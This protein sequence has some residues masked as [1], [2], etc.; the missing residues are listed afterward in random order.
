MMSVTAAPIN[1]LRLLRYASIFNFSY[2]NDG[3]THRQAQT[4]VTSMNNT[5]PI[6]ARTTSCIV[7]L[8]DIRFPVC[9]SIPLVSERQ[10]A[11][12]LQSPQGLSATRR[13][14]RYRQNPYGQQHL[15]QAGDLPR[16]RLWSG[17]DVI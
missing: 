11:M 2:Q 6:S 16:R 9:M 7:P 14:K 1:I 10:R 5:I 12:C 17:I 3:G 15:R 8:S 4:P 13:N